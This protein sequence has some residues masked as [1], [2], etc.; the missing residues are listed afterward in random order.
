MAL[1]RLTPEEKIEALK[2]AQRM[3]KERARLKKQL[4]K[5]EITLK[6]ILEEAEND[7]VI[8]R[9]KVSHLL[10]SLPRV[11]RIRSRELMREIGI[12]ESRRVQGLG[13]RQ[14][15]ALLDRLG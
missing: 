15:A 7:E 13:G 10:Q 4:K 14:K 1:P 12:H 11:G 8:R 2:K 9:M 5:G 3:R 6:E